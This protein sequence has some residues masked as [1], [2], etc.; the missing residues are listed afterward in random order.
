VNAHVNVI[1]DVN[2]CERTEPDRTSLTR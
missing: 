1:V 2:K